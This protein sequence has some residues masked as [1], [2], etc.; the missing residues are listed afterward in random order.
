MQAW[1]PTGEPVCGR[2]SYLL[3]LTPHWLFRVGAGPHFPHLER[4]PISN[5]IFLTISHTA[6]MNVCWVL[7]D[8]SKSSHLDFTMILKDDMF[9]SIFYL[10][11][12]G[13]EELTIFCRFVQKINDRNRLCTK[14]CWLV[15]WSFYWN[16]QTAD[17]D[18]TPTCSV[19]SS[20]CD[21]AADMGCVL[22]IVIYYP[23]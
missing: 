22:F 2:G 19:F 5:L 14:V 9:T 17:Y 15:L 18:I 12:W 10:G 16:I 3:D 4:F 7:N 6:M 1:F 20:S 8:I 11:N 21:L 23:L 13:V